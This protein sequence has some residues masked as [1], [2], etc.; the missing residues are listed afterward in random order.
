MGQLS[1]QT[2][3][4]AQGTGVTSA[5]SECS[6]HSGQS[7]VLVRSGRSSWERQHLSYALKLRGTCTGREKG[8]CADLECRAILWQK[9]PESQRRG[10]K[11]KEVCGVNVG[12]GE[13]FLYQRLWCGGFLHR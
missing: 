10:E 9:S 8:G 3:G 12:G 5:N 13:A 1:H 2:T 4:V 11:Q 7:A 6:G